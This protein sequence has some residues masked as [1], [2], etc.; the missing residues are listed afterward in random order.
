MSVRHRIFGAIGL[1]LLGGVALVFLGV[2]ATRCLG[3]VG[4]R[5]SLV[6]S[7]AS[8]CIDPGVGMGVSVGALFVGAAALLLLPP[9]RRA[10]RGAALGALLGG[11]AA[12][13]AVV[14]RPPTFM[15]GPT[16]SGEV[17]TITLPFDWNLLLA[18]LVVGVTIGLI[19]G[20]RVLT[21]SGAASMRA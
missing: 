11:A 1:V 18:A 6:Q 16:S 3:P 17:I 8:G 20:S 9:P 19:V 7:I 12:A 13:T 2:Q 5:P 15:T 14:L 21:R 10:F 4:V